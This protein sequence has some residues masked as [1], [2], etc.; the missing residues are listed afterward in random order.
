MHGATLKM[1]L[2]NEKED[3]DKEAR[4]N[5]KAKL[6]MQLLAFNTDA[7]DEELEISACRE[8]LSF[9][10]ANIKAT[11]PQRGFKKHSGKRLQPLL[12]STCG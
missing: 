12:A 11:E 3:E 5:T 8:L 10:C 2:K 6:W 9:I 4:N 1:K 7:S